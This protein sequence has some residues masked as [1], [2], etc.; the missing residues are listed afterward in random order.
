MFEFLYLDQCH[1]LKSFV[2]SH[3]P[4]SGYDVDTTYLQIFFLSCVCLRCVAAESYNV[5]A[6]RWTMDHISVTECPL[7]IEQMTQLVTSPSSGAIATF[8]GS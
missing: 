4:L 3:N 7:S 1:P 6:I 2:F 5:C 8:I